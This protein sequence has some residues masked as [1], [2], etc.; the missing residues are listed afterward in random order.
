MRKSAEKLVFPFRNTVYARALQLCRDAD[1]A[2]DL[3]QNTMLQGMINL[4]QLKT[5]AKSKYWLFAILLNF[6][7]KD[8]SKEKNFEKVDYTGWAN[9]LAGRS[10]LEKEYLEDEVSREVRLRVENLEAHLRAPIQLYYFQQFSYKEISEE[11]KIPMGTVMSR[12]FRAR[13]SLV[14]RLA[15]MEPIRS[16]IS[17]SAGKNGNLLEEAL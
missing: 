6:Y 12:I 10:C 11:L 4:S 2:E 3:T 14:T 8:Y 9:S 17:F 5:P 16:E 1:H 13:K 15:F 7:R